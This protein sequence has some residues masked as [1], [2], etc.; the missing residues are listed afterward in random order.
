LVPG[1]QLEEREK[2]KK[3][4]KR[5]GEERRGEERRGE[6]KRREEKRSCLFS[7]KRQRKDRA[8]SESKRSLTSAGFY[9]PQLSESFED[10]PSLTYFNAK[11]FNVHHVE[12]EELISFV[13]V[14]SQSSRCLRRQVRGDPEALPQSLDGLDKGLARQVTENCN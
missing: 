2:K 10:I 4:K 14:F 11:L 13:G 3:K 12:T 7:E 8:P 1:W 6:E 9:F 5:R